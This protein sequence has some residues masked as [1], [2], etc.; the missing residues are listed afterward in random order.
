MKTAIIFF[1]LASLFVVTEL[2]LVLWDLA[3]GQVL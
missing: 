2:V 1:V 3:T